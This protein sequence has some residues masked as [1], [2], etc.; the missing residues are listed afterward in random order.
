[1]AIFGKWAGHFQGGGSDKVWAAWYDDTGRFTVVW[2]R[3]G[4]TIRRK[5]EI[6]PLGGVRRSFD[7]KVA[8]KQREGYIA[9]PFGDAYFG[10]PDP[11]ATLGQLAPTQPTP[12]QPPT[13]T[14]RNNAA[15]ATPAATASTR[16]TNCGT[17]VGAE[18]HACPAETV[19]GRGRYLG[20]NLGSLLE[21]EEGRSYLRWLARLT[22]GLTLD[23]VYNPG[24]PGEINYSEQARLLLAGRVALAATPPPVVGALSRMQQRKGAF[25]PISR[26]A[27]TG[28]KRRD[29]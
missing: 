24:Q 26:P 19:M 12:V 5:E 3:R 7:R 11:E 10:I 16:C 8:E 4:Q 2:G 25:K 23:M 9:I 27:P 15:Q 17:G 18:G 14:A 6:L 13:Q 29:W 1:L 20:Q 28:R 21:T 22:N